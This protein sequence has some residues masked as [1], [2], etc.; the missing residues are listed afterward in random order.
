M[1]FFCKKKYN[2]SKKYLLKY[3]TF[4]TNSKY[5][6]LF[7]TSIESCLSEIQLKFQTFCS[8]KNK[9]NEKNTQ[10]QIKNFRRRSLVTEQLRTILLCKFILITDNRWQ[11]P[12]ILFPSK[13]IS[14]DTSSLS[15]GQTKLT[16]FYTPP[17]CVLRLLKSLQN[18]PGLQEKTHP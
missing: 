13:S 14:F 6:T 18:I 10:K 16:F 7:I 4:K 11:Y 12:A 9:A 3:D 5:T 15:A 1:D 2:S 8:T 17:S